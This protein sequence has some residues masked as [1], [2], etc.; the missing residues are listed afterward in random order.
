[1]KNNDSAG[2]AAAAV[3]IGELTT[4]QVQAKATADAAL[5]AILTPDQQTKFSTIEKHGPR[6]FGPHGGGPGGGMP[7]GPPP[8]Q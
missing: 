7:P 3:T 1:V 8:E 4:Q 2:I 5:Y 6:G